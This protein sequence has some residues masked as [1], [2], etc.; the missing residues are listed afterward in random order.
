MQTF[1]F[2][3]NHHAKEKSSHLETSDY[4][5]NPLRQHIQVWN[6]GSYW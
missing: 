4:T 5:D 2:S 1:Q 6:F 3:D